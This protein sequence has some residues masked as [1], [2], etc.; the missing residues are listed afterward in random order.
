LPGDLEVDSFPGAVSQ[1]VT[2][3]VVNSLV[4][5]F[6]R[7]QPGNITIRARL[8]DGRHGR[9]RIRRRRRRHGRRH[10]GA[11]CSTPSSR[12]SAAAAAAASART[13][14]TTW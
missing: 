11:S 13:S 10:A 14:C 3:M 2:N 5:G 6:E 12:P 4:H 9:L 1:I 7:D 8:E